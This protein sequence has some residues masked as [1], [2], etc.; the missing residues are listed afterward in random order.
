MSPPITAP[1]PA[2]PGVRQASPK[3]A[4][5]AD[6]WPA[7]TRGGAALVSIQFDSAQQSWCDVTG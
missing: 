6:I 7:A 1:A 4:P 5:G 2:W 3:A